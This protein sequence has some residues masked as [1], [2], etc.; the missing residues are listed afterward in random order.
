MD[1]ENF[2]LSHED[3]VQGLVSGHAGIL[4]YVHLTPKLFFYILFF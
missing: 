4:I 3:K 2:K 1:T